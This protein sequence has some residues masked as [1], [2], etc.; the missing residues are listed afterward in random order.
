MSKVIGF[1]VRV[2]IVVLGLKFSCKG[3]WVF[4]LIFKV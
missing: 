3:S 1:C 2:N 4:G